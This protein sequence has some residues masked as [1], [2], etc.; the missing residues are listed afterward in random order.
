MDGR[1]RSGH[2]RYQGQGLAPNPNAAYA[3]LNFI[4]EPKAQALETDYNLYGTPNDKAKPLVDPAVLNNEAVFP[5]EAQFAILE[6]SKDTSSN[7]QRIDIWEEFKQNIG[8]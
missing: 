1:P 3:W 2:G 4:Q 8:A 6:G 7:N 5:T